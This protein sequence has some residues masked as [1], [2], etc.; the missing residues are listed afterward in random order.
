M[1]YILRR[2]EVGDVAN[3]PNFRSYSPKKSGDRSKSKSAP[4][5]L[6]IANSISN[7]GAPKSKGQDSRKV[8]DTKGKNNHGRS[9]W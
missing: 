9:P 5:L 4:G 1:F 3:K 7:L 6:G 2:K 8:H